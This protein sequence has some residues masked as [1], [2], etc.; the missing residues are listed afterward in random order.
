MSDLAF[1]APAIQPQNSRGTKVPSSSTC[2]EYRGRSMTGEELSQEQMSASP[3][4]I[5]KLVVLGMLW[6][7]TR[8]SR[9]RGWQVA[10]WV[11]V[12]VAWLVSVLLT[13]RLA[14]VMV[15][16]TAIVI[17]RFVDVFGVPPRVEHRRTPPR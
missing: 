10:T 1:A 2:E 14:Q 7:T 13:Q 8:Q 5:A 17:A 16:V 12:G 6:G 9:H 3:L 4:H 11:M 15:M